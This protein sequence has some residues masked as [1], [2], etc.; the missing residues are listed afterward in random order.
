M[1]QRKQT[2]FLIISFILTVFIYFYPL[3]VIYNVN[4]GTYL[5]EVFGVF[6][7]SNQTIIPS[8]NIYSLPILLSI[9]VLLELVPIFLYRKRM[10]QFR[11]VTFSS[12]I[13]FG[14]ILLLGYY[15]Y[16]LT[17]GLTFSMYFGIVSVFPLI[18]II[19]N[20]FAGR[21]I[22]K[23]EKLIRSMNRIR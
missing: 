17:E 7:Q 21:A 12:F 13:Q 23:D 1:I 19:L 22:L 4:E 18:S 3:A 2:L 5:L 16:F 10:L 15:I 8:G 20:I 11:I 14:F 9:M 6:S